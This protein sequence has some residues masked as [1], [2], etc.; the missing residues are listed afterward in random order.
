M[1]LKLDPCMV[2]KIVRFAVYDPRAQGANGDVLAEI[3]R[4]FPNA[5]DNFDGAIN[6]MLGMLREYVLLEQIESALVRP[7]LGGSND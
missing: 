3:V 5:G 2:D 6:T 4:R 7:R 1:E